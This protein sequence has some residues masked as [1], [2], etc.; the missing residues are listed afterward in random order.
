MGCSVATDEL[1]HCNVDYFF[2]NN[3]TR[4]IGTGSNFIWILPPLI[5]MK[6]IMFILWTSNYSIAIDYR[7]G[8]LP[9]GP[10]ISNS[11]LLHLDQSQLA[12]GKWKEDKFFWSENR[13]P[14]QFI[15][16]LMDL[17]SRCL[18]MTSANFRVRPIFR[19]L[20]SIWQ[21]Y[22]TS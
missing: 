18:Q 14:E 9:G 21:F 19:C 5:A 22:W 16:N 1:A 6:F 20:F 8:R 17:W 2:R 10:T 3:G 12:T 15:Q 7:L 13:F 4:V 11:L